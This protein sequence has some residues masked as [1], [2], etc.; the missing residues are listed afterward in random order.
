MY[1]SWIDFGPGPLLD[2]GIHCVKSINFFSS[3]HLRLYQ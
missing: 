1:K 2:G 3:V